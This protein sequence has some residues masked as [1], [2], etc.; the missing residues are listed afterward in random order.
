MLVTYYALDAFTTQRR[1]HGRLR[2]RCAGSHNELHNLVALDY[3]L[4]HGCEVCRFVDLLWADLICPTT[5]RQVIRIATRAD[6]GARTKSLSLLW[7]AFYAGTLLLS[8]N[9]SHHSTRWQND[10]QREHVVRM[11]VQHGDSQS[12]R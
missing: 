6:E 3:S 1:T 10:P 9:F 4:G 12:H 5:P 2:R 8:Y 7:N 11:L